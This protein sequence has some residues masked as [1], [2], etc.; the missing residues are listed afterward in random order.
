MTKKTAKRLGQADSRMARGKRQIEVDGDDENSA[1]GN[2]GNKGGRGKKLKKLRRKV[3][4]A[5]NASRRLQEQLDEQP[6]FPVARPASMKRRHWGVLASFFLFVVA[7]LAAVIFYL[8]TIAEDQYVSTS[9]FVVR[10]Q[11]TSGANEAL[12][13]SRSWSAIPPP[14]TAMCSMPSFKAKRSLRSWSVR[15]VCGLIFRPLAG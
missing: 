13:A 14:P 2:T 5:E 6:S 3:R 10:S 8:W 7:P 12:G 15:S 11:E 9:G 1:D 4:A